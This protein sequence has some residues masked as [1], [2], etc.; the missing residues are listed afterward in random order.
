MAL[1]PDP[2]TSTGFLWSLSDQ[3]FGLLSVE[4]WVVACHH[5]GPVPWLYC[6]PAQCPPQCPQTSLSYLHKLHWLGRMTDFFLTSLGTTSQLHPKALV[7][8]N[9][10]LSSL[11][12]RSLYQAPGER[13]FPLTLWGNVSAYTIEIKKLCW[14]K[15]E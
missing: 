14:V 4:Y 8:G 9:S 2:S 11:I 3:V 6:P 13:N 1:V 5:R 12:A 7:P 15:I 10:F